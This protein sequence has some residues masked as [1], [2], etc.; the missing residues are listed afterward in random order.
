M[1]KYFN[2]ITK[3][4]TLPY[5]FNEVLKDIPDD[6]EINIL[7]KFTDCKYKDI[8]GLRLFNPERITL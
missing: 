7:R 4:L 2:N 5:E 3:T 8:K 1:L 6:T